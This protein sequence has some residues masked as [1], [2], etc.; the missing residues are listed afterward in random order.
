MK[1]D[2]FFSIDNCV[3][4]LHDYIQLWFFL[5]DWFLIQFELIKNIYV[6]DWINLDSFHI[7][8]NNNLMLISLY[9]K[10]CSR[11]TMVIT[12]CHGVLFMLDMFL[13]HAWFV[14][15]IAYRCHELWLTWLTA[16]RSRRIGWLRN[17]M[18]SNVKS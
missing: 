10:Y 5:L 17:R 13:I 18:P 4:F 6:S 12:D 8:M 9:M 16:G 2:S 7:F 3:F 1:N 11:A 15:W 14:C